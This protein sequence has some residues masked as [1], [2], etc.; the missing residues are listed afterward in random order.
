MSLNK[1][2]LSKADYIKS[3]RP[4]AALDPVFPFFDEWVVMPQD[5]GPAGRMRA[6][7]ASR[8]PASTRRISRPKSRCLCHS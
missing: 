3:L 4:P 2:A 7:V 6:G 8:L 5:L 1:Q